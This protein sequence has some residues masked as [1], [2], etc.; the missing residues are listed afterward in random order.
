MKNFL[1]EFKLQTGYLKYNPDLGRKETWEESIKE[2]IMPMHKKKYAKEYEENEKLR[3]YI[4]F[5]EDAYVDKLVLGSQ[6][7]LQF[8]GDP[9]LRHNSKMYNCL[10]SYCDRTKFFRE[11]MWWLLSGCGVGFSVQTQHIEKLPSLQPR[12]KG[13]KTFIAGDSIEGWADCIGVLISSYMRD[14]DK[15]EEYWGYDIKFDLSLIRPKGAPISSGFKAPGPEPLKNTLIKIEDLIEKWLV[16]EGVIVRPILAYDIVMH[17]SDAVLAGGVRR[18]ATI[19]IF[20]KEDKE[21]LTSKTG[22]WFYENPQRARSNN[23]VALLKSETEWEEF[24]EIMQSVRQFGEPGFVWLDDLEIVYN[25]CV[26]IGMV[27]KL[28]IQ[29]DK[30]GLNLVDEIWESGWQGCNLTTGN[31]AMC[32]DKKT[33]LRMCKAL[34]ILGTLQAGYTSFEYVGQLTEEIFKKESLL[35]CAI[36]GWLDNPDILLNKD[37]L[38]EGVSLIKEI[39]EELALI[40]GINPAAR[41]TCSKP[42]GNGSTILGASSGVKP[43][44]GKRWIRYVQVNPD[45]YGVEHFRSINPEMFEMSVYDSNGQDYAVGFAIEGEPNALTKYDIYGVKHLEKVKFIMENWVYPGTIID[46]CTLPEVRHNVSN[47]I[48]VDNWDEVSIYLYDNRKY[49]AGVSFLGMEG[50]LEYNQSPFSEVFTVEELHEKYGEGVLLA[51][52]LIVDGLHAFKDNLWTACMHVLNKDVDFVGSREQVFYM[53]DWVRRAKKFAKNY[54]KNDLKKMT[55][56]LKDVHRYYRYMTIKK[57][58]KNINWSEYREVIEHI[59]IDTL[60]AVACA[61]G[62]CDISI[63][64]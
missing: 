20:S 4:Q 50:S 30:T 40:L 55:Y 25:P 54:F 59:N 9:I 51:S 14:D 17:S 38:A 22:N 53:K 15:F 37:I 28:L 39:N 47:T 7:A 43:A 57:S 62:A 24:N 56:C 52:G 13:T 64:R 3:E 10:T 23:S 31:G 63:P 49:F 41:L 34:A 44:E 29:K 60:G 27:P 11:A 26:E 16:N 36:C 19:C 5:A 58:A 12:D 33:F 2:R 6:R 45:E 21:M 42:D 1:S 32:K 8:G 48:A 61:G 35:G 18:S 46:R